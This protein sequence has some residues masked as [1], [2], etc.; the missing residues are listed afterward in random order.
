MYF[1]WVPPVPDPEGP[2]G[3]SP[4]S[5]SRIVLDPSDDP[6]ALRA[7][8]AALTL[9]QLAGAWRSSDTTMARTRDVRRRCQ[10]V[11]LRCLVLDEVE[12]RRPRLYQRWLRDGGPD[13]QRGPRSARRAGNGT[14]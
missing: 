7:A 12:Q 3:G 4:D 9:D 10:V 11:G 13:R 5:V 1:M 14:R 6:T 8:L 2:A